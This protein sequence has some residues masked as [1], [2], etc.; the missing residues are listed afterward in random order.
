MLKAGPVRALGAM[1]G[2]SL[3]GVDAAIVETD[4]EVILGFGETA[5]RAYS[6]AE[7][8]TIAAALGR[9]PGEAGV[10][11]AAEV[12][13]TAHAAVLSGFGEVD[14]V[15]FHGQTLAHDPHGKGT[16]QAGDGRV[17]AEVLGLP[18]VWDFRSSDVELGGEGAPLAPF[19]HFACTK[20]IG[21]TA[22]LAFVNLGG[23][24][25][26]TWVDPAQA[27]PE[28]PGALL[29]FDTG[30]ANAPL[31]DLMQARRGLPYDQDAALAASGTPDEAVLQMLLERP[32]FLRVPPKSLDRNDFAVLSQM[33][34]GLNDADAA[35]TLTAAAAACVARGLEHC[36]EYPER[37]LV[38]GGGRKNPL[39]MEM[40]I[41][42]CGVPALQVEEL[43][44]DG[45]MLE[46]QAF[47][48]LAVRVARGLPTSAPG[49]TGVGAAVGG[50][51]ISR[52]A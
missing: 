29:A 31:N 16:H 35:A 7:R 38:T 20:W 21:A 47:A 34:A 8:G 42:R 17:L 50:G 43:G 32:Y 51:R 48:Y 1:S 12:V 28:A 45:D 44:L 41:E 33:V 26:L 4:G 24:G 13:E 15:G 3:D 39:M 30:P 40:L 11:E 9:W 49:T 36:P 25:N 27:R 52:P 6:A 19:F 18:V 46:A 23:V 5:Y 2:T 37:L 22:P 10:E 14:L